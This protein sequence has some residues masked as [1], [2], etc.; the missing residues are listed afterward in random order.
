MSSK[1]SDK[2]KSTK[3]DPNQEIPISASYTK[4][5]P[6]SN[7]SIPLSAEVVTSAFDREFLAKLG[8]LSPMSPAS[9]AETY[10]D[11][12]FHLAFLPGK[13]LS[14]MENG[15]RKSMKLFDYS[16]G[17]TLGINKE[18]CINPRIND[19]RFKDLE[20]QTWP[21]NIY[22]QAFLLTEEW[23]NETTSTV[24]G[25]SQHHSAVLPF[26]TRQCL[27]MV[28]PLNFP[29]TN[30]KVI[31]TTVELK[32]MNLI[33]GAKNF[34]VDLQRSLK[35][36]PPLG[37]E[38]F[39]VGKDLAVTQGKVIYQN[40]L[41]ELIQ[42]SPLTDEVYAEPMLIIPA[43]IMKYY[44]LDLS[45]HNS[46]VKYMVEHN[47]TVFMISWKNPTS[48]DRNIGFEEYVNL[49]IMDALEAISAIIPGEK[50]NAVGYCL[51]GTLLSIAASLMGRKGDDR[52]KSLSLFASQVDFED[53]GELLLFIDESQIAFLE[54][55]MW[56]KGY[57]DASR[58][59]GTFSML[60]SYDLIWSKAIESYLLGTREKLFDLMAWDAD[61]T[62]MPYKMQSDYLRKLYLH[63]MLSN[64]KFTLGGQEVAL[65]DIKLPIFLVGT[66][67]DHVA[68]WKS[69]YKIHLFTESDIT[70]VLTSGGHNAGI[71]SE[72]GHVSAPGH[73]QRTYQIST[74]KNSDQNLFP[75]EWLAKTPHTTGS[76]WP[77]WDH[78]LSEQ[79]SRKVAPPPMGQPTKGYKILREA[80]GLYVL[81]K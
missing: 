45:P 46:L 17:V 5:T 56:E 64:G 22:Q 29:F 75:D 60:H 51:G 39:K 8:E 65:D 15:L 59:A 54:D 47:H 14:L 35:K 9:F 26:L 32:G 68:P 48:E 52:I 50:V 41:I 80:P 33:E 61:T 38:N 55:I 67:K 49:G 79:S 37:S 1:D 73:S 62:R 78:W 66:Q 3:I 81:E 71:V 43:W 24:R 2:K 6:S 31:Q 69:V 74:H 11:W 58:M 42:Y 20:W 63:N 23:W 28:A 30:P 7:A 76:W 12:F 16:L 34:A 36:E 53:A 25:V 44:I 4:C 57:L 77:A 19:R 27:D 70:F 10:L 18:C 13:Q 21:Y 72:P 40:D